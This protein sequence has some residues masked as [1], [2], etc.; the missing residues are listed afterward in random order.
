MRR[1]SPH[2]KERR[3]WPHNPISLE[4]RVRYFPSPPHNRTSGLSRSGE[5]KEEELIPAG[6]L[7]GRMLRHF[8]FRF[9]GRNTFSHIRSLCDSGGKGGRGLEFHRVLRFPRG[10][11]GSGCCCV[12]VAV[13]L[14]SLLELRWNFHFAPPLIRPTKW[15]TPFRYFEKIYSPF[16]QCD[17]FY[18][19][20]RKPVAISPLFATEEDKKGN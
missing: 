2:R 17:F 15:K 12:S 19:G 16:P 13:L 3:N 8:D 14:P 1:L 7:S 20:R 10:F 5:E 18:S 6:Y 11:E 4:I 9:F